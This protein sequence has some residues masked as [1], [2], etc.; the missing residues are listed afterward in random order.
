MNDFTQLVSASTSFS[1]FCTHFENAK[2]AHNR[3]LNEAVRLFF[4]DKQTIDDIVTTMKYLKR[5]EVEA[6]TE[7][8]DEYAKVSDN[9][10]RRGEKWS[11]MEVNSV[12][13]ADKNGESL[14]SIALKCKRSV[15]SII[16]KLEEEA[17]KTVL[18]SRRPTPNL[19]HHINECMV[20][21][22]VTN[23]RKERNERNER[24]ENKRPK[25]NPAS[26]M[27]HSLNSSK[28]PHNVANSSQIVLDLKKFLQE[29]GAFTDDLDAH[30]Q[31]FLDI[32]TLV[33]DS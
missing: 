9:A 17:V 10:S 33:N 4:S 7:K 11:V 22:A 25:F 21:M 14:A 24:N 15:W 31:E 20:S 28:S 30:F 12:K 32:L 6:V 23:E 18:A 13:T 1:N 2:E 5:F 8:R 19:F 26:T 29:K 3:L 16:S 27:Q